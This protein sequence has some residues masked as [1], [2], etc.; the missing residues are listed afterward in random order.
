MIPCYI[1]LGSNLGQPLQQLEAAQKAL[2]SLPETTLES[3]SP[4]YHSPPMGPSDQPDYLNAVAKIT[5][6][7]SPLQLLDALQSIELSQ[8]RQRLRRW[9]ERTL[10]LDLLLYGDELIE[11][12]RLTVPHYGM[13]ERAFVLYPL[14]DIAPQLTLPCGTRLS[15]L[16]RACDRGGLQ[17]FVPQDS[18]ES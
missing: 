18:T 4:I 11:Q 9:G 13:K 1:A 6:R 12:P 3:F 5:T 17:R 15:E 7:L 14:A 10:D 2:S 16:L 8:G